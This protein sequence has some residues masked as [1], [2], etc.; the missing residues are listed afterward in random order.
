MIWN[1]IKGQTHKEEFTL[2]KILDKKSPWGWSSQ[3]FSVPFKR[4]IEMKLGF[5]RGNKTSQICSLSHFSFSISY[6]YCRKQILISRYT[7]NLNYIFLCKF[8]T[9]TNLLWEFCHIPIFRDESGN[10]YNHCSYIFEK[11]TSKP[12]L[13]KIF[14][15]F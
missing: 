3:L 5:I 8:I 2:I 1:I 7:T 12:I 6:T 9:T 13:T 14:T 15:N 4:N 10:N 11:K